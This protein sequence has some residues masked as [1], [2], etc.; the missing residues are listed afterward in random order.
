[1]RILTEERSFK[2]AAARLGVSASALSHVMRRLEDRLRIRLLARTTRSVSTTEAGERLLARLR[3]ALADVTQALDEL[4]QMLDKPRGHIRITATRQAAATVIGP[5]LP[6]FALDYPEIVVELLVEEGLTDIVERRYDA[7][8]RLGQAI[9]KDM[10]S[11]RISRGQVPAIVASPKYFKRHQV[12]LVPQDLRGQRCLG[13]RLPS[14]GVVY[15]WELENGD[16]KLEVAVEG[17]LVFNDPDLMIDAALGGAGLAYVFED[18]VSHHI[19]NGR[20]VRVL[21]KWCAPIPGFFLYYSSRRQT[22]AALQ[23]FVA[24]LRVDQG[25]NRLALPATGTRHS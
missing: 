22:P 15:R 14:A 2:R 25:G 7:G 5:L 13:F 1:M 19:R 9:A 3:P 12:P 20:L 18:Q 10:I 16:Q 21:E 23:A 24:A 6:Q 17:P 11:V 8:V 4:G